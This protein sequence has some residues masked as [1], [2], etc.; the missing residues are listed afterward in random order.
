MFQN[1]SLSLGNIKEELF[2][3]Y[4]ESHVL[5]C[6]LCSASDREFEV[7]TAVNV[8]NGAEALCLIKNK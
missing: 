5:Q 8:L 6:C 2:C 1:D 4:S 7:W 3:L